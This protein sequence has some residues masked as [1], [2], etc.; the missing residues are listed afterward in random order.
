MRTP[1]CDTRTR[2]TCLSRSLKAV[3]RLRGQRAVDVAAAMGLPLRSYEYFEAAKGRLNVERIHQFADVLDADPI[4]I[5]I[6]VEICSPD[7]AVRCAG[8]KLMTILMMALQEFDADAADQIAGL[9]ARTLISAFTRLF[10]GL[11]AEAKDRYALVDQW[12]AGQGRAE[13]GEGGAT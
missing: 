7:F 12:M 2:R 9:D 6:G 10:D 5:L 11:S 8:N 13:S 1:T 4:A 3:R